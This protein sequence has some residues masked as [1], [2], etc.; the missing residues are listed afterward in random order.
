MRLQLAILLLWSLCLAAWSGEAAALRVA[1]VGDSITAGARVPEAGRYP[2]LLEGLLGE[3]LGRKVE[4]RNFG[5]SGATALKKGDASFWNLSTYKG[6]IA[7]APEVVVIMLGTNDSK[8]QNWK[9]KADFAGDLAA[10][11]REFAKLESKPAIWL[12][13]PPPAYKP[14]FGIRGEVI[15]DE[16]IPLIRQ[17]AA[18]EKVNLIDAFTP[19]SGH[20]EMF[21]DGVHPLDAGTE[22]LAKTICSGIIE[23][24]KGKPAKR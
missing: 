23:K 9:N 7:F 14:A 21:P 2:K 3:A 1:C 19:L 4:A 15:K 12:V 11:V 16:I 6:A 20:A 22:L 13:L 18:A 8:A 5:S 24:P 10:M 17:V